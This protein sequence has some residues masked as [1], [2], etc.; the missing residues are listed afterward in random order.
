MNIKEFI[1]SSELIEQYVLGQLNE[2]ESA[3]VEC[4]ANTYPEIKEEI[5]LHQKA[6]EMYASAY[7]KKPPS[8][9]KEKI[10][11]KMTFSE[12]EQQPETKKEI[13]PIWPKISL[14][15]SVLLCL[16]CGWLYTINQTSKRENAQLNEEYSQ[17]KGSVDPLLQAMNNPQ[18]QVVKM[19]GSELDPDAMVT[20]FWNQ[21]SN[22]VDLYVNNLP[23]PS[24]GKQ[25]Q[26]WIIGPN[27]PEDMGMLD[28]NFEGKILAMKEVQN[29]PTAFAITLE[30][31]GGVPSPTLEQL[32]VIGNV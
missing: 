6:L 29:T 17:Y 10:L 26:L 16:L 4:L 20:V 12:P 9:L 18:N 25:Y 21:E 23:K 28:N 19:L 5:M 14:A 30:K 32:Y 1:Q 22:G 11:G 31:E 8:H 3:G 7:E 13:K 27:G 15:A 2:K 24:Y